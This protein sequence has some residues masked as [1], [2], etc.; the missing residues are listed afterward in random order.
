MGK[1]REPKAT[2]PLQGALFNL[3]FQLVYKLQDINYQ[4]NPMISYRN[5]LIDNLIKKVKQLNRDNFAVR[6]HIKDVDEYANKVNYE[7]LTYSDCLEVRDEVSPLILPDEGDAAAF[8]FDALIFELELANISDKPAG[9]Y[10]TDIIKK[11]IAVSKVANIPEIANQKDLIKKVIETDYLNR[12]GIEDL[13]H[14]RKALR[15]LIKYIPK[16]SIT[17]DTDFN[18]EILDT[19]VNEAEYNTDTLKN[20]RAKVEYYIN[21]HQK[22]NQVIAKLK[23][24]Q[25]LTDADLKNLE[26][27][28][29]KDIGTKEDYTK[30]YGDQPLGEF[31]RSIVGLDMNSAKEA[32]AEYL[33]DKSLNSRQIYFLNQV[34]EYIVKNGMMKDL[35]VLQDSPFIDQGNIIELFGD[36]KTL[37]LGIKE[38]INNINHNADVVA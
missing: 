3:K 22:D 25:P 19:S 24:N 38:V 28:F 26:K 2:L 36:N 16:N 14:I 4:T 8:R 21:Q 13:E 27:I 31:I 34:I 32:F 29:W 15:D 6:Q 17:F 1:G 12:A 35:S 20:Y 30:E 5:T 10:K 37:W 9:R 7:E 23:S 18:D 33:N 11:I